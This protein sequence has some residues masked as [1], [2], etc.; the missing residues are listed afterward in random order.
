[1]RMP[2]LTEAWMTDRPNAD[3]PDELL[4]GPSARCMLLPR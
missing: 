4:L 2:L 1:M 3:G